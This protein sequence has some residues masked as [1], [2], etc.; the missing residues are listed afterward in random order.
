MAIIAVVEVPGSP[1]KLSED[2][3]ASVQASV[4]GNADF[5]EDVLHAL[6]N[7][8]DEPASRDFPLLVEAP[9]STLAV[10]RRNVVVALNVVLGRISPHDIPKVG[11]EFVR[12]QALDLAPRHADGGAAVRDTSGALPE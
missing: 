2:Q 6:T 4:A 12:H 11:T 1:K 5:C 10:A 9:S 3:V 7:H 8:C